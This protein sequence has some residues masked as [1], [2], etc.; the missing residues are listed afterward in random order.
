MMVTYDHFS[1]SFVIVK[2]FEQLGISK[3]IVK[4]W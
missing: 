3:Q 1:N 2:T 4:P